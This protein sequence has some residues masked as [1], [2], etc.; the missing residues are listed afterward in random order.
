M[1]AG[2]YWVGLMVK[3]GKFCVL[4]QGDPRSPGLS[5]LGICTARR[6]TPE[7]FSQQEEFC[8]A[9]SRPDQWLQE[10]GPRK[11]EFQDHEQPDQWLQERGRQ[12][13]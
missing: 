4:S 8:W 3:L 13:H 9:Y 10:H 5:D 2:W 7:A 12:A 11:Q 1:V 6:T